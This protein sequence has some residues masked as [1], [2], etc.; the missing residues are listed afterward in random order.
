MNQKPVAVIT[1]ASRGIGRAVAIGL[2]AE[3]FDIV[4]I[5]RSV[6]SP[7]MEIL[8]P[9]VEKRGSNFFPIGLEQ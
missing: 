9:E 1:G 5:A 3:G 4:A 2:A 8:A 7:G 6:D